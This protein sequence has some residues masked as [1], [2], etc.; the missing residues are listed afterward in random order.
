MIVASALYLLLSV[1]P[2]TNSVIILLSLACIMIDSIFVFTPLLLFSLFG[3]I[4]FP[5]AASDYCL[6]TGFHAV[7]LSCAIDDAHRIVSRQGKEISFID[8]TL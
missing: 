5:T 4:T 8:F 2:L 1:L 7:S 6:W 3:A